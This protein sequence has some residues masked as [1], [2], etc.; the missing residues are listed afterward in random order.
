MRI[1]VL[2]TALSAV[3]VAALASAAN[4]QVVSIQLQESGFPTE[5][6]GSGT[7][8]ASFSGNFGTFFISSLDATAMNVLNATAGVLLGS[9]TINSSSAARGHADDLSHGY[10]PVHFCP[11]AWR[12]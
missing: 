5:F 6:I 9:S 3:A 4:A 12:A 7:S 2:K 10:G 1:S 8:T 11:G